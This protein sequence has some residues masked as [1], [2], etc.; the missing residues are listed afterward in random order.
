LGV[1]KISFIEEPKEGEDSG[2]TEG[3]DG[4]GCK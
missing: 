3:S 4:S 2:Y 1:E